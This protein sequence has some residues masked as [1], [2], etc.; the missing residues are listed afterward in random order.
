MQLQVTTESPNL[1][2]SDTLDFL[3]A[4]LTN[5]KLY[6]TGNYTSQ[7]TTIKKQPITFYKLRII[8]SFLKYLELQ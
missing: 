5:K 3:F 2:Q 1:S 4:A 7:R 8:K 6:I